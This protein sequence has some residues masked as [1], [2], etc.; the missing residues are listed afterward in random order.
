MALNTCN[1]I[2]HR[3]CDVIP[4]SDLVIDRVNALGSNQPHQMTFTDIQGRLIGDI[5]IPGV[6]ADEDNDDPLTGVVP[7]IADDIEIPGVDVE[8][9]EA[10][11]AVPATQV[12]IGDIGIPHD[13]PAPIEVAPTQAKQAPETPTP[14][15]LPVEAPGLHR[16]KRVWSQANQGYNPSMTCSNYSFAVTHLEIQG[17]LNPD[18]RMC[19]Q[20]DFYQVEPDDVAAIMTQLSQGR[21][22]GMG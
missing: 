2:V 16:S 5:E 3:S 8:G 22:E 19:V 10:Q 9:P 1:N 21:F 12:E 17:V 6:D 4:M 14:V 13:N 18:A 20:E 15:A 7:V 11:D